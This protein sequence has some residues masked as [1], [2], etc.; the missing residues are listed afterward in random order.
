MAKIGHIGTTVNAPYLQHHKYRRE[1]TRERRYPVLAVLDLLLGWS[2]GLS[3]L[4]IGVYA[5]GRVVTYFFPATL[6]WLHYL[7]L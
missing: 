1:T 5:I 2:I 4:A 3:A 7:R 6:Y